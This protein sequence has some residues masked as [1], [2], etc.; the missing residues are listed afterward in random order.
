M[1]IEKGKER[2]EFFLREERSGA[3]CKVVLA[4]EVG[5]RAKRELGRLEKG[6]VRFRQGKLENREG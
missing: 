1:S 3:E 5:K 6:G 2:G 4:G